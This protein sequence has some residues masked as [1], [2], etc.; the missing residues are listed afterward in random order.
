MECNLK[1]KRKERS[2][3]DRNVIRHSSVQCNSRLVFMLRERSIGKKARSRKAAKRGPRKLE[4]STYW[5]TV[6]FLIIRTKFSTELANCTT[7]IRNFENTCDLVGWAFFYVVLYDEA[8]Y[9]D[10]SKAFSYL[11]WDGLIPWASRSFSSCRIL[12]RAMSNSCLTFHR[13]VSQIGSLH[14]WCLR[15]SWASKTAPRKVRDF[16]MLWKCQ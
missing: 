8:F 12:S 14:L 13:W 15:I 4:L 1:K 3:K 2:R 5:R 16:P 10:W 6:S 7:L 9:M 11:A